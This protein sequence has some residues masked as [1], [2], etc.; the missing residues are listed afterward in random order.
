MEN[1]ARMESRN[2]RKEG[3]EKGMGSS[4]GKKYVGAACETLHLPPTQKNA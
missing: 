2:S 4:P 3:S 1:K